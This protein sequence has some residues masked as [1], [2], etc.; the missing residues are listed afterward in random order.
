MALS[1]PLVGWLRSRSV[2]PTVKVLVGFAI[3]VSLSALA[4]CSAASSKG[5]LS[6]TPP[7]ASAVEVQ[8]I[9]AAA[10][11]SMASWYS[12]LTPPSVSYAAYFM[13]LFGYT[14]SVGVEG[15]VQVALANWTDATPP[16]YSA[17]GDTITWSNSGDTWTW[18]ITYTV[19]SVQHTVVITITSTTSG[20]N[21]TVT[22]DGKQWLTGSINS[23]GTG[24]TATISDPTG[25]TP[26]S[27]AVS[28]TTAS[29][30]YNYQYT[31]NATGAFAAA[32]ASV[33]GDDATTE[34]LV[35][36]TNSTGSTWTLT[37]TDNA[38]SS[39]TYP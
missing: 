30:P 7:S 17:G 13:A 39:Y 27:I 34:T 35:L 38:P 28:W 20:W 37:Y 3:L 14:E 15:L 32:V 29:S 26:G 4:G 6:G 5:S 8:G 33:A 2:S 16:S 19:S 18:T 10:W 9:P 31:V 22:E 11:T 12:G 1:S 25:A 36:K 23:T 21:I 24:G